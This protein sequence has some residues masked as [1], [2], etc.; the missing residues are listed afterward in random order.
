MN[1]LTTYIP[2]GNRVLLH[3]L[4]EEPKPGELILPET[5]RPPR[6]SRLRVVAIGGGVN[7]EHYPLQ[8]GDLV[9]LVNQPATM[10]GVEKEQEFLTVADY[11]INVIVREP[12][13]N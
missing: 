13:A 4:K 8:V 9:Q 2:V 6:A 11:D 12:E 10:A 5:A 7:K 1:Q 3:P